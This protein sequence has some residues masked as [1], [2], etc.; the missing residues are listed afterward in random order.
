MAKLQIFHL[1]TSFYH[2][3]VDDSL[4]GVYIYINTHTTHP[5]ILK[6]G[7]LWG[8]NWQQHKKKDEP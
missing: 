8:E 3:V 6:I 5:L 4:A 2:F 7:A 1:M